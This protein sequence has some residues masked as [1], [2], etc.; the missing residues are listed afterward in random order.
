MAKLVSEMVP[1]CALGP[2]ALRQRVALIRRE[3]LPRARSSRPLPDGRAWEFSSSPELRGILEEL[4]ELERQCCGEGIR[5]ELHGGT[6]DAGLQLEVHGIDP[7]A[8]VF[9]LLEEPKR[10][11]LRRLAV[12]GSAGLGLSVS[13]FCVLP[14]LAAL[15][16]GA[17][18]PAAVA[19]LDHPLVVG[20]GA[21]TAAGVV[22]RLAHQRPS[23]TGSA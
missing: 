21:V 2:E 13:I 20:L 22:W 18:L 9:A 15:L 1:F 23:A 11:A 4:I 19:R 6:G 10:G 3:I 14:L 7:N 16:F 12:A 5:F 17:S 8:R